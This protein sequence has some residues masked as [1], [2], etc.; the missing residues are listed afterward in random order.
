MNFRAVAC[1]LAV[2]AAAQAQE[3]RISAKPYVPAPEALRVETDLIE[4]GV[5]VRDHDG[6]AI[7]GLK[8]RT[9][10]AYL[11]GEIKA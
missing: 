7:A 6:H 5:V 3:V 10:A 1:W 2:L 9:A 11:K 4:V 8:R